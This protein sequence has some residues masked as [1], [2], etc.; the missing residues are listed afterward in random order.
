MALFVR[1]RLVFE[2]WY[3]ILHLGR[4]VVVMHTMLMLMSVPMR[5]L[6]FLLLGIFFALR[7]S[8]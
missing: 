5:V 2:S 8:M 4:A 7:V 3:V 6:M 1:M